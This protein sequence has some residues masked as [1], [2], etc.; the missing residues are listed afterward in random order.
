M[1][2]GGGFD[3][4]KAHGKAEMQQEEKA[5]TPRPV[6]SQEKKE[7]QNQPNKETPRQPA[8]TV[9][10]QQEKQQAALTANDPGKSGGG[11][12]AAKPQ[13]PPR[14][15]SVIEVLKE[16]Y[17]S[18][19]IGKDDYDHALYKLLH[20]EVAGTDEPVEFKIYKNDGKVEMIV[21]R[22]EIDIPTNTNL[23]VRQE[24]DR[25]VIRGGGNHDI[26]DGREEPGRQG[27]GLQ[28]PSTP[29]SSPPAV[30]GNIDVFTAEELEMI[31]REFQSRGTSGDLLVKNETSTL[32]ED[33]ELIDLRKEFAPPEDE[34]KE[35]E[36]EEKE[37]EEPGLLDGILDKFSHLTRKLKEES[38]EEKLRRLSLENL[39]KIKELKEERRAIIGVAYVLKQFL[40][41]KFNIAR[42]VTYHE[43]VDE[44]K[45]KD[46]DR[47]LKEQLMD[48]FR[49]MPVMMYAKVPLNESLPRAYNLAERVIKELSAA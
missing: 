11:E 33:L 16:A 12:N 13:A 9:E 14:E 26:K 48:F 41:V 21:E 36:P 23:E 29:A 24:G 28:P 32:K 19:I 34:K 8:N 39:A 17:N 20:K 7:I 43:L 2:L 22:G 35:A 42:E 5:R 1:K 44:L 46:M 31:E 15:K 30:S 4:L 40:Q 10:Q 38:R 47:E 6:R 49:R 37:A 18:R 3:A 25:I 45:G 27:F